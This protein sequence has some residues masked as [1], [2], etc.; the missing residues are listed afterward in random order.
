[1]SNYVD[2]EKRRETQKR[3]NEKNKERLA[4]HLREYY[5]EY[6]RKWRDNPE[7]MQKE[8]DAR[9]AYYAKNKEEEQRKGREYMRG[10]YL[11]NKDN[12]VY[13]AASRKKYE[14]RRAWFNEFLSAL[15]CKHCGMNDGDCLEFH[16]PEPKGRVNGKRVEP[17]ITGLLSR[18]KEFIL[19]EAAKCLVLCANC[20]RKEHARLRRMQAER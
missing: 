19:K 10:Y 11:A 6:K 5:R 8:R 9:K 18:S 3:W 1:M 7:Q 2:L 17:A 13:K 20:H 15:S 12:P 4:E 14:D 16:H